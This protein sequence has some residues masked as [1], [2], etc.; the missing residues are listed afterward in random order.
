[1]LY[2]KYIFYSGIVVFQEKGEYFV[3]V[4]NNIYN[5]EKYC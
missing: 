4:V 2:V 3:R 1:M 5:L